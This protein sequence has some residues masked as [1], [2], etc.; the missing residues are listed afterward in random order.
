M[1]EPTIP[2][3][4]IPDAVITVGGS[5][6]ILQVNRQLTAMFGYGDDELIGQPVEILLPERIRQRHIQYRMAF[7]DRPMMRPMGRDLE[8]FGRRKD[9]S[10]FPVDIMLNP[11]SAEDGQ[12]LAVIRDTTS[13][14]A[15][16]DR[17]AQLAIDA[18]DNVPV[19]HMIA[20][21]VP[22]T[23]EPFGSG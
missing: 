6:L 11:L 15:M 8:L 10:E 22:R 13:A 19:L 14:K 20:P 12:V 17:L 18:D 9:G 7:Q 16:S 2:I 1:L 4:L 23:D 3:D 5:G 21:P